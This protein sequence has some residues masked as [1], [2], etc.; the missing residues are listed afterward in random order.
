MLSSQGN[1]SSH[2]PHPT[3]ITFP[4]TEEIQYY[5]DVI[6]FGGE[7]TITNL[8]A[9][10]QS[11]IFP[12]PIAPDVPVPW[13]SPDPRAILSFSDLHISKSLARVMRNHP[14]RVSIDEAFPQ[15]IEACAETP[16]VHEDSTWIDRRIID[17]YVRLH[18][19]GHAHS[20][21]VWEGEKLVGGLYG[22]ATKGCFAGES[23][24]HRRSNTSKI[25][26]VH[27]VRH[28]EGQGLGWI[29]V[30]Q[31]TDLFAKFG[32]IEIPRESYLQLL[33]ATQ[34]NELTLF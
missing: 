21:E 1:A 3:D 26:L 27:L 13:V 33:L 29:D 34:A 10:Y 18:E 8:L 14:Y 17:G 22:V 9:A 6:H 12:W 15:V 24:F 30:Q 28:L 11:G 32:A 2:L 20:V 25:A 23:M 19:A 31:L 7:L 4:A 5:D 16:R